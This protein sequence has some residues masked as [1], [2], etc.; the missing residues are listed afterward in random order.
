MENCE[1]CDKELKDGAPA[2]AMTAGHISDADAGFMPKDDEPWFNILCDDCQDVVN[3]AV[4]EAAKGAPDTATLIEVLRNVLTHA[5]GINPEYEAKGA[6]EQKM[7][8]AV[9]AAYQVCGIEPGTWQF[10][11][12]NDVTTRYDRKQHTIKVRRGQHEYGAFI[13]IVGEVISSALCVPAL[14]ETMAFSQADIIDGLN[15]RVLEGGK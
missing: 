13:I 3:A 10:K 8:D 7:V 9:T 14:H 5:V 11:T 4:D 1:I 15:G 2:Y 12:W 6:G